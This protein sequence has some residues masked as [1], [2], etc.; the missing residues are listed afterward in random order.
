[1]VFEDHGIQGG[2]SAGVATEII[3]LMMTTKQPFSPNPKAAVKGLYPALILRILASGCPH[4]HCT[5]SSP[6]TDT[7]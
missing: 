5:V 1:M 3:I 4:Q 2:R 7:P 6:L